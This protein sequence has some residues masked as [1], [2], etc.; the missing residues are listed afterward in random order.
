MDVFQELSEA[1]WKIKMNTTMYYETSQY[2]ADITL[3]SSGEFSVGVSL[4]KPASGYAYKSFPAETPTK[5]IIA[6]VNAVGQHYRI[7]RNAEEYA[8]QLKSLRDYLINRMEDFSFQ[9]YGDDVLRADVD[10]LEMSLAR[11][12]RVLNRLVGI[13]EEKYEKFGEV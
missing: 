4:E 8:R 7:Y 6:W 11:N 9:T 10:A 2:R 12:V 3:L 5:S 1:N 13:A